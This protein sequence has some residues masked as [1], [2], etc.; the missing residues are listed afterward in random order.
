MRVLSLFIVINLF[1]TGCIAAPFYAS[2]QKHGR[3][4]DKETGAPIEGAVVVAQWVMWQA[5]IGSPGP[6]KGLHTVE[7]VTD[8]NGNYILPAWGPKI[9]PPLS[10]VNK[11]EVYAF[12]TGYAPLG[13]TIKEQ[14]EVE[15]FELER[16]S[17]TLEEQTEKLSF[18]F[19]DID[20]SAEYNWKL[21]PK[22][23]VE[24]SKENKKL[25]MLGARR[26]SSIPDVELFGEHERNVLRE[27][28]NEK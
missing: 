9:V 10:E 13:G 5:G 4:V 25:K 16:P 2:G 20:S 11:F 21:F 3:V 26:I 8:K 14:E 17:G 18:F 15:L 19:G 12:K 24:L 7:T 6:S 23:L 28:I 22:M 27:L 1:I